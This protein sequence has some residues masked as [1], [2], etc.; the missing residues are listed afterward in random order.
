MKNEKYYTQTITAKNP[1]EVVVKK[2]NN[3]RFV[4]TKESFVNLNGNHVDVFKSLDGKI[5]DI[6][7]K[8]NLHYDVVP[9]I[10]GCYEIPEDNEWREEGNFL[11]VEKQLSYSV[12]NSFGYVYEDEWKVRILSATPSSD[13]CIGGVDHL[14]IGMSGAEVRDIVKFSDSK[15]GETLVLKMRKKD[16]GYRVRAE[17]NNAVLENS[18]DIV[19]GL[20]PVSRTI[21][22]ARTLDFV[23]SAT[24]S[25]QIEKGKFADCH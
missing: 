12:P 8:A 2:V 15:H 9:K 16:N 21:P 23:G 17:V 25:T 14:I 20:I 6:K 18:D 24:V 7:E 10:M 11:L 13:G 19:N 22:S 3:S 4:G 5:F 1:S